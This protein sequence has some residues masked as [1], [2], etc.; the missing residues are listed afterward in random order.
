MRLQVYCIAPQLLLQDTAAA[1]D[2]KVFELTISTVNLS[3]QSDQGGD[4]DLCNL[5]ILSQCC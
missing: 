3:A 2:C 4:S 1:T 5:F